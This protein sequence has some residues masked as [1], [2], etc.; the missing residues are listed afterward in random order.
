[1]KQR[2]VVGLSGGVDSSVSAWLLK[3]QGH[4]V[5]GVFMKNWNDDDNT[6]KCTARQDFLDVL[7]V[8]EVLGIEVEAVNFAAEY[9][10]RVF[11]HFLEEYSAGRTPNPDVLCNAEIKFRAF[12]DYAL[13]LGADCIATGHYAGKGEDESGR[14]SLLRSADVNKD[15]SYFL[16]RLNQRQLGPTLFPLSGMQKPEVRELA[17]KVG[18]PN[19]AKKDSTGICFI[20]ER[21]FREFLETYL[22]KRPGPMQTPEGKVVGTHQGL[23]YYTI[24]QREGL[25]IGGAGE[26]WFV[27]GKNVVDNCLIVVQGHAH[28]LLYLESLRAGDLAWVAEQAPD[29]SLS[30]TAKTRY[31]QVDASCHIHFDGA[32]MMD[33]IFDTPQWAVTPGQSVVLYDR[34]TCLGGGIIA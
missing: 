32:G 15:Q 33:V 34:Q 20:G 30:Y 31:R 11:S 23:M 13:K 21:N 22:P 16:Y 26:P 7:A 9:K 4:E 10:E 25:K 6:D 18:L 1:M 28:P 17:E 27:A 24:G 12:L 3:V 14:A 5:V 19:F 8:A 2:V 29:A